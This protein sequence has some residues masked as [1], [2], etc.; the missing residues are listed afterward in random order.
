MAFMTLCE[1][2]MGIDPHFDL[3]TYF[4]CVRRPPDPDTGLIVLG[5][6]SFMSRPSMALILF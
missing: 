1:T 4:F 6:Q 3:W 5:A 2:Y